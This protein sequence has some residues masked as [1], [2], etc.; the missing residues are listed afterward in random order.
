MR[1]LVPMRVSDGSAGETLVPIVQPWYGCPIRVEGRVVAI[2][3]LLTA[4]DS[5][6]VGRVASA[7]Q[8]L[9]RYRSAGI[10]PYLPVRDRSAFY[11][12]LLVEETQDGP[13]I[14]DG[15]H[16]CLVAQMQGLSSVRAMCVSPARPLSAPGSLVRVSDLRVLGAAMAPKFSGGVN[17]VFRPADS[18][19]R[20]WSSAMQHERKLSE[21]EDAGDRGA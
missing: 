8:V 7:E 15:T 12:G 16:R 11:L 10:H 1:E 14:L 13:M 19:Q 21:C 6:F 20:D 4:I 18:W 2:G 17:S 5:V 3:S 9:A